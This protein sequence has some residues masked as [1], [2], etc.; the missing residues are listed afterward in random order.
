MFGIGL[1]N[2]VELFANLGSH[3]DSKDIE[4]AI[5]CT[6]VRW[7]YFALICANFNLN[8]QANHEKH[9]WWMITT[10]EGVLLTAS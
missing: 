7:T 5:Q 2:Y 9:T 1:S 3:P 8:W 6:K 10:S 4:R